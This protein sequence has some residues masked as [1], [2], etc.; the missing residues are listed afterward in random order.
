MTLEKPRL[1]PERRDFMRFAVVMLLLVGIRLSFT[2][3]AYQIFIA[4]PFYYTTA[5][6]LNTYPKTKMG[7][8]LPC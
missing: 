2:Y 1:F 8:Q 5:R 7:K 4:K 6:V 3:H